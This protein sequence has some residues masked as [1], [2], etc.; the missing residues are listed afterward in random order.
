LT[1]KS[2]TYTCKS[3]PCIHIVIDDRRKIFKVFIED[4]DYIM[5]IEL[6]K[7]RE[8]CEKL[9]S[10]PR[11]KRYREAKE[12]EEDYLARKYLGAEPIKEEEEND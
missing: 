4:Y 9:A 12:D 3:Y 1:K 2:E 11:L 7:L 8:A 5:P 6:S 10:D